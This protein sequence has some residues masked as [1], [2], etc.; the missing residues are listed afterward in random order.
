MGNCFGPTSAGAY[1]N[2]E[3]TYAGSGLD[4]AL[5]VDAPTVLL[6]SRRVLGFA[7]QMHSS[8]VTEL[9][10]AG[11]PPIAAGARQQQ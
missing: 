11:A 6:T 4:L 8:Q 7:V 9:H 5:R 3:P 1:V 10:P 2:K